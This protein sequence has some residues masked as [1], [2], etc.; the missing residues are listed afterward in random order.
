MWHGFVSSPFFSHRIILMFAP[1][2]FFSKSSGIERYFALAIV[3]FLLLSGKPQMRLLLPHGL[4]CL[5]RRSLPG[6]TMMSLRLVFLFTVLKLTEMRWLRVFDRYS[7]M[8]SQMPT[9]FSLLSFF[10]RPISWINSGFVLLVSF[11]LWFSL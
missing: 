2:G 4:Y 10:R 6:T 3:S 9:C 1:L 7:A 11:E 8:S 5:I